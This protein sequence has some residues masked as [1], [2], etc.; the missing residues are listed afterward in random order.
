M[1]AQKSYLINNVAR[2]KIKYVVIFGKIIFAP[3][4]YYDVPLGKF[5]LNDPLFIWLNQNLLEG[6]VQS[7][8]AHQKD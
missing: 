8:S 1:L 6:D 7:H 2:R 4:N 5:V 3:Q